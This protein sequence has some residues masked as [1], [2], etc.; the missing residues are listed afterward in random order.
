MRLVT[1]GN[2]ETYGLIIYSPS[3]GLLL[4]EDFLLI[5]GRSPN[6]KSYRKL[7]VV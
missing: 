1:F 2:R 7:G 4:D 5:E 6:Q 3:V